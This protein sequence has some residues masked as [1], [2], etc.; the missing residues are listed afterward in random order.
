[1]SAAIGARGLDEWL[2]YIDRVHPRDMDLGLDRVRSVAHQMELLPLP[3][4]SVIVAGTNGKGSTC[5]ALEAVLRAMGARVGTTLSPHLSRFNERVRIDGVACDDATLCAG[6]SEIEAARGDVPLT[7]FEF[8]ALLA[9]GCFRRAQVD[10]AVLEIGLGGRLDAFNVVDADI[11]VVTSIGLDHADYL[12]ESLEGIGLE[13]AGV[14]RPNQPVVISETVTDS[15]RD[16]AGELGCAVYEHGKEFNAHLRPQGANGERLWD[17]ESESGAL[18]GLKQTALAPVNC[19]LAIQAAGLLPGGLTESAS[20]TLVQ[21]LDGIT[22]PGRMESVISA[23]RHFLLDVAHNPAAAR[24][25]A[26]QIA[27]SHPG[28]VSVAIVGSLEDKDSAGVIAALQGVVGEWI[29]V[30][31]APPRGVTARVLGGRVPRDIDY[32]PAGSDRSALEAAYSATD[33]GDVILVCGCFA[34]VESIRSVLPTW[35]PGRVAPRGE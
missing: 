31:V 29:G 5:I 23:G 35:S 17:F 8:S 19:A 24:F 3:C 12:G 13:K 7:Y 28:G 15:V 20:P 21:A 11:A 9:L 33:E 18:Y 25:L 6:L 1:M 10:I 30:D 4:R 34:V 27:A 14:F 16:R 2:R 32:L 22:F 26:D